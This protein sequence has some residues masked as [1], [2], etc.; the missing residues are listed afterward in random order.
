MS[1]ENTSSHWELSGN[2]DE[3]HQMSQGFENTFQNLREVKF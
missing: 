3:R 1:D 2:Y